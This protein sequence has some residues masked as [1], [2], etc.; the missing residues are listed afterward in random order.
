MSR[1]DIAKSIANDL[2]DHDALDMQ[3]FGDDAD[4]VLIL[5]QNTVLR[6]LRDV[7]IVQGNIL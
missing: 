2:L 1:A 5:V 7:M 3:N 6:H 4:A